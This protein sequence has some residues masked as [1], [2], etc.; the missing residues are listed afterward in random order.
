MLYKL[1]FCL[2]NIK[3]DANHWIISSIISSKLHS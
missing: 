3:Y 2:S 1:V